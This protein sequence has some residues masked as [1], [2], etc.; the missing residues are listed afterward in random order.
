MVPT[1]TIPMTGKRLPAGL[2]KLWKADS[3]DFMFQY[4][5]FIAVYQK[6]SGFRVKVLLKTE[7]LP[8]RTDSLGHIYL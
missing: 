3:S 8:N 5:F 4:H 1:G 7:K 6:A 2:G